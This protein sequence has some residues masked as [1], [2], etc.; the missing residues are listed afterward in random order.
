MLRARVWI[1]PR[2]IRPSRLAGS[3]DCP[4]RVK[5]ESGNTS[6]LERFIAREMRADWGNTGPKLYADLRALNRSGASETAF[7][8]Q[9]EGV[10]GTP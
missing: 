8:E 6:E 3:R 9:H 2:S 4:V 7:L 5:S 1:L 10:L